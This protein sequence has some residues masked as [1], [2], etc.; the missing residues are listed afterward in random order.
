MDDRKIS[1]CFTNW[2]RYEVLL[3]AFVNVANDDRIS[4][5]IVSDDNSD[6]EIYKRLETALS[7]CPKVKL[8]RNQTNIDCYRNKRQSISL[9]SNEWCAIIDSD[10]EI[11]KSYIDAL[12]AIPEWDD[13]TIYQPIFAKPAFN[14]TEFTGM[15]II[16]NNVADFIDRPHFSTAMNAMNNFCNV[17]NYLKVWDGSVDPVTADSIFHNYNHLKSGGIIYFTPNLTY[18]HNIHPGSH[19]VNN[20][21]RTPE[22]FYESIVQKLREL[23]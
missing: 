7:F 8:F 11:D 18:N 12:Y 5:I 1:L 23:R 4:E 9:A 16:K 2:N 13:E 19:Y 10:N 15:A 20:V 21:K 14:F 17:Y 6:I 3:Q 22:G